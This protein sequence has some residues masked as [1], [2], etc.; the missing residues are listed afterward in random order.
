MN[1]LLGNHLI[2]LKPGDYQEASNIS[3]TQPDLLR[4]SRDDEIDCNIVD[5]VSHVASDSNSVG[6]ESFWIHYFD[7]SKTLEG[8][9]AGC[10]QN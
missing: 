2:E 4:F 8:S 6:V 1:F 9:G 3:D 10:V 7:G 5:L